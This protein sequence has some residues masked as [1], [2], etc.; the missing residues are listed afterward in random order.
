MPDSAPS[1]SRFFELF[2]IFAGV[3]LLTQFAIKTFFPTQDPAAVPT[4]TLK[5]QEKSLRTGHFPVFLLENKTQSGVVLASRC[6]QPPLDVSRV[7]GDKLTPLTASGTAAPCEDAIMVT[8]GSTAT[9][10]L[11]PW[12]YQSQRPRSRSTSRE[13]SCNSSVR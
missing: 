6:P 3:Y 13:S 11:A 1:R 2:L 8:P 12:K 10:S 9:I 4:L 7:D 5:A